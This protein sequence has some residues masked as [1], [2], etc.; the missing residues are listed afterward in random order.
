MSI[1]LSLLHSNQT[2]P[3]T[4]RP[5]E[6]V[7]N[8]TCLFS[9]GFLLLRIRTQFLIIDGD[10]PIKRGRCSVRRAYMYMASAAV[11]PCFQFP[12]N[13]SDLICAIATR[14]FLLDLD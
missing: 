3:T 10:L 13:E 2:E 9:G 8:P 6:W 14:D 11:L 5:P 12:L 1:S 4:V 7:P